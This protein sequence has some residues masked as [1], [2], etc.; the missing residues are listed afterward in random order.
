MLEE[1]CRSLPVGTQVAIAIRLIEMALPIWIKHVAVNPDQLKRASALIGELNKVQNGAHEI[2]PDFP[3]TALQVLKRIIDAGKKVADSTT[4]KQHL[5]TSMEPLTNQ[6]WD[7]VLP[8]SVRLVFTA[9]FN[10]LTFLLLTRVTQNNENHVYVAINQACDAILR[11]KILS[12][13]ELEQVLTSFKSFNPSKVESSLPADF[14][15][16]PESR[17]SSHGRCSKCGSPDAYEDGGW[18]EFTKIH[19]PSCGHD[20]YIDEYELDRWRG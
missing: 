11:E 5:A 13:D 15:S 17:T 19:C 3:Q 14:L 12:K 2:S 4:L 1:Y 10:L 9:V 18:Y 16:I 8:L 6:G 20:E 7:G